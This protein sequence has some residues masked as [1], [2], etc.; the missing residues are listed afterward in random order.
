MWQEQNDPSPGKEAS[1]LERLH[2]EFRYPGLAIGRI[3]EYP[4]MA[5]IE[6]G[7]RIF[8]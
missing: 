5:P 3:D 7:G 1:L 4:M 2:D 8:S 6:D